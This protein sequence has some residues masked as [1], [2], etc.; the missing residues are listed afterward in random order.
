MQLRKK[1]LRKNKAGK[2]F[3]VF[4]EGVEVRSCKSFWLVPGLSA[5]EGRGG[6]FV[7]GLE[8]N[9]RSPSE[10]RFL[11]PHFQFFHS[12]SSS[13]DAFVYRLLTK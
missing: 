10:W 9:R 2:T 11:L 1:L 4:E 8:A 12:Q 7:E 5:S 6:V 13:G 3:T